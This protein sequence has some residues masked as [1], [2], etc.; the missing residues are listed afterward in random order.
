MWDIYLVLAW[1]N[2][3]ENTC[4][5]CCEKGHD[6]S[7]GQR[8][9]QSAQVLTSHLAYYTADPSIKFVYVV[10]AFQEAVGNAL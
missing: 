8:P 7:T 10:D 3:Q 2:I 1:L 9:L 4:W 5:K 6:D